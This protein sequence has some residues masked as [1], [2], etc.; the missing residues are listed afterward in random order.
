MVYSMHIAFL[1]LHDQRFSGWNLDDFVFFR[2][3][4]AKEY[5]RRVSQKHKVTLFILHE[6][7]SNIKT[8][9]MHGY[10]IKALPVKFKFPPF[11]PIGA[12]H[13]L[14]ICRQLEKFDIIHFH[15]YYFWSLA[16]VALAKKIAKWKL[17]G[18]Y[19]GE[20]ELQSLGKF[21]HSPWLHLLDKLLVSTRIEKIWLSRLGVRSEKISRLPNVGVDVNLFKKRCDYED[22]PYFIYVGRMPLKPRTLGEKDPWLILEIADS[23]RNYL[24]EFKVLMVG[25]G[26]GLDRL[27][28]TCKVK[29]LDNFVK[30]LGYVPNHMLPEL[31]SKCYFSFVPIFMNELDPFWDGSLKESLACKTPVI[32]FN[33]SIERFETAVRKFGLLLPPKPDLAAKILSQYAINFNY[34]SEAGSAGRRF[35]EKHCSWDAVV[36]S[37]LEVYNGLL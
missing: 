7:L 15:N 35:V 21:I 9:A 16:P 34:V 33:G 4:F 18:Q 30:F 29:G 26:P 19:H 32:G 11:V 14:E 25:D 20:P 22:I 31:Y 10:T 27:K 17:V 37:L 5:A 23:L 12:S 13:N 6:N 2:Y 1:L 3:H 28:L 8:Y 36:T 24:K